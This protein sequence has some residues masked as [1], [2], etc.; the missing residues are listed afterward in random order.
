[1]PSSVEMKRPP[2]LITSA[3]ME[4]AVSGGP[5]RARSA[6]IKVPGYLR[7]DILAPPASFS[8]IMTASERSSP[9]L[10]SASRTARS[11]SLHLVAFGWLAEGRV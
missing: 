2:E 5:R 10:S 8:S 11:W 3:M 7:R 6:T 9:D 1:M 4:E